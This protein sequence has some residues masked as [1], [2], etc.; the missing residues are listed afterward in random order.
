MLLKLSLNIQMIWMTFTK[1]LKNEIQINNVKYLLFL[2]A[3]MPS[4]K[5]LNPGTRKY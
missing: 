3:D 5:T 4:N 2:I 1:I